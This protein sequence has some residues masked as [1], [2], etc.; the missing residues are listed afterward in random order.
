MTDRK[1]NAILIETLDDI[2][3]PPMRFYN[4]E[5][6]DLIDKETNEVTRM[7]AFNYTFIFRNKQFSKC[8]NTSY[9]HIFNINKIHN[10]RYDL[11][12]MAI[13]NSNYNLLKKK[14]K[15]AKRRFLKVYGIK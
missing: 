6:K 1:Y 10:M 2:E 9:L 3:T 14:S 8:M 12:G 13:Y 5:I 4:I 11:I 15:L 7:M